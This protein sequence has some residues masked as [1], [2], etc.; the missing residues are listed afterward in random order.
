[1]HK[2]DGKTNSPQSYGPTEQPFK[3]QQEKLCLISQYGYEAKILV[4]IGN[5]FEGVESY[6]QEQNDKH[7]WENLDFS[8]EVREAVP[9]QMAAYK[10]KITQYY[11]KK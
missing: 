7:L 4:E 9:I 5:T 3:L 6:G 10:Q 1:M 2:D 11:N 8:K